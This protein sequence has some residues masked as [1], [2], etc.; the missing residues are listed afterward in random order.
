VIAPVIARAIAPVIVRQ[1]ESLPDR[2]R[3]R[4]RPQ[5]CGIAWEEILMS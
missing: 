1:L 2:R 3:P 5:L 4:R